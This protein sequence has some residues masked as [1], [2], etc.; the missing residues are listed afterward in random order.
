MSWNDRDKDSESNVNSLFKR[1]FPRYRSRG[2]F[3]SLLEEYLTNGDEWRKK[4]LP[5]ILLDA[6]ARSHCLKSLIMRT[7]RWM[8]CTVYLS[9][10]PWG[11][12]LES[13]DNQRARKVVFVYMQDRSFK[14][15]ACN[16]IKLSVKETKWSSLLTRTRAL[17]FCFSVWKFDFGPEKLPELSR[18]GPLPR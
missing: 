14:N 8:R 5:V 4:L 13:P 3:N 12:F 7:V 10:R 18:S 15:F 6:P 9:L 16:M 17:I 1:H 2:I 11:L